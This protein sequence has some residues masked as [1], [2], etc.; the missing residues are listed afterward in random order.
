M[1]IVLGFNAAR[2]EFTCSRDVPAI[3]KSLSD[4]SSSSSSL[5]DCC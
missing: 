5:F 1:I 3:T 4:L 2:V